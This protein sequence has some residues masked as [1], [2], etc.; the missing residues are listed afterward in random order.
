MGNILM[1]Y[2]A[3]KRAINRI[4]NEII[5]RNKG[6]EDLVLVGILTRGLNISI[7]I[8]EKISE[9][10]G[11]EIPFY[12]LNISNY[13]DD[14][15]KNKKELTV[16]SFEFTGKLNNKTVILVDDVIFTGRSVR[17]ALDAIMEQDRPKKVQLVSLIDRGHRELPIRA[18]YIGKNVPT[19]RSEKI[20]VKLVEVDGIDEVTIENWIIIYSWFYIIIMLSYIYNLIVCIRKGKLV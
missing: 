11:V 5:E 13:R 10:E 7:R 15:A 19:S 2:N 18:D 12:S 20:Q 14:V 4:S 17:A 8:R 9:I 1:D 3:I 16:E 6:T